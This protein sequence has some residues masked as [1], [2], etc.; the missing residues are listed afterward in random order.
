MLTNDVLYY[1]SLCSDVRSPVQAHSTVP[2]ALACSP[3]YVVSASHH[4][5]VVYVKNI[6]LGTQ[7]VLLQP[8]IS[9]SAVR[10]AAFHPERD[11]VFLLG[12]KDG[13]IAA[14]N[15]KNVSDSGHDGEI[16]HL[17]QA[18]IGA[19]CA[20][21]ILGA[22]A[23]V[24]R[25]R[26][27]D[28]AREG[29][30]DVRLCFR[31]AI[32]VGRIDGRVHLYHLDGVLQAERSVAAER[33][34]AVEWVRGPVPTA[35]SGLPSQD[36]SDAPSS[37]APDMLSSRRG[38]G[39]GGA[40]P[41]RRAHAVDY[42]SRR[43]QQSVGLGLPPALKRPVTTLQTARPDN[44]FTVHPDEA[45]EGTVR[46]TPHF[47]AAP[48][49]PRPVELPDLFSPARSAGPADAFGTAAKRCA[50]SPH[51]RPRISTQT[52]VQSPAIRRTVS[53]ATS[54]GS[55]N[56]PPRNLSATTRLAR[57]RRTSARVSPGD[58][59][60]ISFQP[61]HSSRGQAGADG[62]T[63]GDFQAD[64]PSANAGPL[65]GLR[66]LTISRAVGYSVPGVYTANAKSKKRDGSV[67]AM[68]PAAARLPALHQRDGP[69]KQK[70]WHPGN[71]LE[72]EDTWPTDSVQNGLEDN[73]W[74]TDK[75]DQETGRHRRLVSFGR[76]PARQPSRSKQGHADTYSTAPDADPR[77]P[78]SWRLR[79]GLDG[80]TEESALD[81]AFTHLSPSG[82]FAPA[83]AAVRELFPRTSSLSPTRKAAL[84]RPKSPW[85]KAKARKGRQSALASSP[86][87]PPP[88][89]EV[90]SLVK[91][92]GMKCA[93]CDMSSLRLSM[94]E[95]EVPRLKDE[96]NALKA[97]L[98]RRGVPSGATSY[99]IGSRSRAA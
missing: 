87:K 51:Q 64:P 58:K 27:Q 45:E 43:S 44:R 2:I 60:R 54:S 98:R 52:F 15:A 41:T 37:P 11:S 18:H 63:L 96:M 76:P 62:N 50:T 13:T 10:L 40:N 67:A 33:I 56:S 12:F 17:R 99:G 53:H 1:P 86:G 90:L 91:S 49:A 65:V 8:R 23:S 7:S 5:P 38:P 66:E 75:S 61:V 25:C 19:T 85:E 68:A 88:R 72:R 70:A 73:T 46:R 4:P 29:G 42:T 47:A 55:A 81:T 82:T 93:E 31:R 6:A 36:A 14:Y 9:G 97:V 83:S 34:I 79:Q 22:K 59:R 92:P 57:A 80:S 16:G 24:L 71:V 26:G 21:F 48:S 94:L 32:A 3:S 78:V 20:M 89:Q 30:L 77:A 74:L 28:M 84:R 35:I 39:T 95:D 69:G